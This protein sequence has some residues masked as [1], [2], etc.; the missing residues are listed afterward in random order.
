MLSLGSYSISLVLQSLVRFCVF[1][2]FAL[3]VGVEEYEDWPI[4]IA[5]AG[6]SVIFGLGVIPYLAVELPRLYGKGDLNL[7]D[8]LF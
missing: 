8:E 3:E 2:Y 5:F 4:I 6:Y 1:Y 7:H